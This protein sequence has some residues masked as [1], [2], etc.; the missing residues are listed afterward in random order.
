MR[1]QAMRQMQAL[2]EEQAAC[3]RE[4]S[5]II[6]MGDADETYVR[7]CRELVEDLRELGAAIERLAELAAR[8]DT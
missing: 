3:L 1:T 5:L 6:S 8:T 7:Y 4:T 2:L